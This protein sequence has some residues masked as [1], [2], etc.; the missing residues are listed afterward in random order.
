MAKRRASRAPKIKMPKPRTAKPR[1]TRTPKGTTTTTRARRGRAKG[2]LKSVTR[3]H[4]RS[5][6]TFG[7]P[8]GK[9]S[10]ARKATV[11]T[12]G[13]LKRTASVTKTTVGKGASRVA[14]SVRTITR[15]KNGRKVTRTVTRINRGGKV[16]VKR[17]KPKVTGR[18]PKTTR[19]KNPGVRHAKGTAPR[20]SR[21]S[22]GG[23]RA[24]RRRKRKR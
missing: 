3:K 21:Q 10:T 4:T 20:A 16:T 6:P 17:S 23:T 11:K 8:S 9:R 18:G 5:A 15:V 19:P 2:G 1:R 7:S 22:S 24:P 14:K 12:R 13:G